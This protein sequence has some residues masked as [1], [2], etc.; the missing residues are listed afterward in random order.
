MSNLV[1]VPDELQPAYAKTLLPNVIYRFPEHKLCEPRHRGIGEAERLILK[2]RASTC[3]G[4]RQR[5]AVSIHEAAHK[6]T[7]QKLGIATS[8]AGQSIHHCCETDRFLIVFGA[9]AADESAVQKLSAEQLAAVSVA[10]YVAERVL[11]GEAP[12]ETWKPDYE[13]FVSSGKDGLRLSQ[14]ILLWKLAEELML[15][16]LRADIA[17]QQRIIHEAAHFERQVF[18]VDR[19]VKAAA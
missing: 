8:Y 1:D 17:W 13:D 16:D 3:E 14:L 7:M 18:G 6:L 12:A 19:S 9:V 5:L 2:L 15:D 11:L 4:S 10:G